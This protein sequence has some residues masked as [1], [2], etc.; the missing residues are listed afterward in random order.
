MRDLIEKFGVMRDWYPTFATLL[1][2]FETWKNWLRCMSTKQG[3]YDKH[4][5]SSNRKF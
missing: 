2:A 1:L 3:L 5:K 4:N